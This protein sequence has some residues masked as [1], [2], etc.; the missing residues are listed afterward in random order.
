MLDVHVLNM[1]AY[2]IVGSMWHLIYGVFP[3]YA[4]CSRDIL[5]I[6]S[7]LDQDNTDI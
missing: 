4:P 5:V 1:Y 3:H 2:A 7:N 6:H